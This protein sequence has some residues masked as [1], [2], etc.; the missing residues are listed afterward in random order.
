[1]HLAFCNLV[2]EQDQQVLAASLHLFTQL[3]STQAREVCAA[4]LLNLNNYTHVR[5]TLS[6]E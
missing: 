1:M 5:L 3:C 2:V 4:L 6:H